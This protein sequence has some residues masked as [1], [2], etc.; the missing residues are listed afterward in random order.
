MQVITVSGKQKRCH[1]DIRIYLNYKLI[2]P[3]HLDN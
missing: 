2:E 3:V 1:Y